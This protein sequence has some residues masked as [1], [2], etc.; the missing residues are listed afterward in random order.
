M[1]RPASRECRSHHPSCTP[2]P[3]C[4]CSG[5]SASLSRAA[6]VSPSATA[7]TSSCDGVAGLSPAHPLGVAGGRG[8]ALAPRGRWLFLASQADASHHSCRTRPTHHGGMGVVGGP[9]H[10]PGCERLPRR[11]VA[12]VHSVYSRGIH[13]TQGSASGGVAAQDGDQ[14]ATRSRILVHH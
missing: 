14:R 12:D 7:A 10:R 6:W 9:A 2:S 11:A 8:A 5:G 13:K 3:W 1:S 4:A